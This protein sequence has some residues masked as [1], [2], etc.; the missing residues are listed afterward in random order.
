MKRAANTNTVAGILLYPA[1]VF[2]HEGGRPDTIV[3]QG[4]RC[5]TLYFLNGDAQGAWDIAADTTVLPRVAYYQQYAGLP[6][7][8]LLAQIQAALAGPPPMDTPRIVP[9]EQAPTVLAP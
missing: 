1:T 6:R 2:G 8:Q 9:L 4:A 3:T 7:A 5:R